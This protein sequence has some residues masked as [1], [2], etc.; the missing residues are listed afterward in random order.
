VRQL[1]L[2]SVVGPF[3]VE[4]VGTDTGIAV[5]VR[6]MVASRAKEG[7]VSCSWLAEVGR[8]EELALLLSGLLL[9]FPEAS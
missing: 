7:E 9:I 3:D 5:G 4:A 6:V 2:A 8:T 1:Y